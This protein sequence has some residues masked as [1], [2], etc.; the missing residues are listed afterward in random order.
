MEQGILNNRTPI[1]PWRLWNVWFQDKKPYIMIKDA[2]IALILQEIPKVWG[3]V[4]QKQ[5]MKT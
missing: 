3:A 1:S 2:P 5:W 4:S